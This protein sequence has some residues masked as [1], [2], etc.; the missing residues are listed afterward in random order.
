VSFLNIS[1]NI[2]NTIL[3]HKSLSATSVSIN[4]NNISDIYHISNVE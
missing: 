4:D 1:T 2:I 3:V